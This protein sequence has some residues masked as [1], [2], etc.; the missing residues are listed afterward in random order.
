M[1]GANATAGFFR[2]LGIAPVLG[3]DFQPGEDQPAAPRT[4]MLSYAAWKQRY[5][6]GRDVLGKTVTLNG[7]TNLI[8]GVLPED[9]YFPPV[10]SSEFFTAL[11][12]TTG[13][14]QR[15]GCHSLFGLARLKA[16]ISVEAA[17]ANA[18]MIARQLEEQY[19]DS[20]RGQGANVAA[21]TQVILGDIRPIL[22][23]LLGGAGL[24]LAIAGLNIANLL[25]VRV[26]S[27]KREIAVRT[28]LGG[29][30]GRLFSQFVAEGAV[31]VA[32][33]GALGVIGAGWLMRLLI[34]L[35]PQN[36]LLGMPYL[37]DIGF[38]PRVVLF[39]GAIAIVSATLFSLAPISRI[40]MSRMRE[41]LVAGS[42]GNSGTTWRQFGA[43][44]V[45][46]EIAAAV[47]LMVGAGLL[48]QSLYRLLHANVG[49][50]PERLAALHVSDTAR[51]F[52]GPEEGGNR[53]SD[54]QR[55][56]RP[57]GREIRRGHRMLP[58]IGG[59]TMWIRVPGRPIMANT[60]RSA[61]ARSAPAISRRC[62]HV[63]PRAATSRKPTTHP[64]LRWSSSI[65]RSPKNTTPVKTP[66]ESNYRMLPL[67][68]LPSWK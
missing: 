24:L 59:N 31:L 13:C 34:G 60:T 19:P 54:P 23:L 33:G 14:Y 40:S 11:H 21:L 46:L 6:A 55:G 47:V 45:A 66:S 8:I 15:R 37:R 58:L 1:A 12:A 61:I 62:A 42:R 41:G 53:A 43:R 49:F 35:V 36:L 4:V 25:L 22:L 51:L 68:R 27:R 44:L 52:H 67:C 28:A 38:H 63:S 30:A 5:G 32:A 65:A 64:S 48:G 29:S 39:A 18:K 7:E 16:G 9:F 10:G 56:G 26:E 20:N 50:Q 3:R 57:A 17:F 2:T